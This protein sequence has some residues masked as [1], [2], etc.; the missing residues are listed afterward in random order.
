VDDY[1]TVKHAGNEA[2]ADIIRQRLDEAGIPSVVSPGDLGALAGASASYAIAVPP[3]Q[4]DAA[5]DLLGD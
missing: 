2:I 1:V 3:D 5:R 4:A